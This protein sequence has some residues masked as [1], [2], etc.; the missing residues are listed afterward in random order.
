MR[1]NHAASVLFLCIANLLG[2]LSPAAHAQSEPK[3]GAIHDDTGQLPYTQ[4]HQQI[5]HQLTAFRDQVAQASNAGIDVSYEQTTLTTAEIFLKFAKWD[6]QHPEQIQEAVDSWWPVKGQGKSISKGLPA[7]Q[8][9]DVLRII[10]GAS[11]ELAR[12]VKDPNSRRKVPAYKFSHAKIQDGY[13][14]NDGKP[15]FGYGFTWMPSDPQLI[16]AYGDASAVFVQPSNLRSE[17]G[18]LSLRGGLQNNNGVRFGFLG[19]GGMP[20]WALKKYPD[21]KT[22]ERQFTAY[23]IDHP[24]TK[25]VWSKVLAEYAPQVKNLNAINAGYMLANEP[26]WY[27]GKGEWATGPVSKH[28]MAKLGPWLEQQHKSVDNLNA[29]WGTQHPSFDSIWIQVPIDTNKIGTGE[30]H[31]WCRFNMARVTDWFTFLKQTIQKHDPGALTHI[32][33]IPGHFAS[34][35]RSHGLDFE[36]L[37]R[38]QG[39]IGCDAKATTNQNSHPKWKQIGKPWT[40]RYAMYWR[41]LSIPYDFFRSISPDKLIIDSE[42]H[43]LSTVH[44][45]DPNMSAE[46]VRCVYWLAHLHGMGV[47]Q[48]WYWSRN[49]EGKPHKETSGFVDSNLTQP[50]VMNAFGRT[51]KELNAFAPEVVALAKKPKHAAIFYSESSAIQNSAYMDK[52]SEAYQALYHQGYPLGFVTAQMLEEASEEDLQQWSVVVVP[53]AD[54]T[55]QADIHAL[56]KYRA[57]QGE[58]AIL[59]KNSLTKDEY[60]KPHTGYQELARLRARTSGL[61]NKALQLL[62]AKS[63]NKDNRIPTVK[64]H[65]TNATGKPGCVWRTTAWEGGQLLLVINLGKSEAKI[66]LNGVADQCTDLITNQVQP[67]AFVL[68]TY[69][70]KLIHIAGVSSTE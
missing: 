32:K 52:I 54:H 7:R 55:T 40:K 68:P 70:V 63:L 50:I 47:N 60:G 57:G 16:L 45:R 62:V 49:A 8:L 1:F 66:K 41:N 37:V 6:H 19:H 12:V 23:D 14:I 26:H 29:A 69:G 46:Y 4:A 53:H 13:F 3:V 65:E 17:N 42:F 27:T 9:N 30:W 44:W 35:A 15:L 56:E 10:D 39:I 21:I 31:D 25:A 11:Q 18:G 28:T 20:K 51:M 67:T 61:S 34:N 5:L 24:G 58:I 38:L 22:G 43:G 64:L 59:G 48:T 36:S 2:S 33:V